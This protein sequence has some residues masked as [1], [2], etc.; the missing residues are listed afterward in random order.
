M[1]WGLGKVGVTKRGREKFHC[2]KEFQFKHSH[3]DEM[4]LFFLPAF[5]CILPF[6][7]QIEYFLC[8]KVWDTVVDKT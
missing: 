5:L 6:D 2:R 4:S 7:K 3:R 8:A 1:S